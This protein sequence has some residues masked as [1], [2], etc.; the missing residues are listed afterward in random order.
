MFLIPPSSYNAQD[1]GRIHEKNDLLKSIIEK[2]EYYKTKDQN[3]DDFFIR[4]Q[5]RTLIK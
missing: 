5:P 1:P 3:D 4:V 2:V